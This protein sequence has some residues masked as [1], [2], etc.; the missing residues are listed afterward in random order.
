MKKTKGGDKGGSNKNIVEKVEP[1]ANILPIMLS[2][3][4]VP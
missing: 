4:I 3:L 2:H 1:E